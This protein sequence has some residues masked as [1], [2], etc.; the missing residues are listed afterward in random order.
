M[1]Y[2][3]FTFS[4]N[5]LTLTSSVLISMMSC[6]TRLL[7]RPGVSTAGRGDTGYLGEGMGWLEVTKQT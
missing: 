2:F 1:H 6:V 4:N 5:D 3:L 7:G